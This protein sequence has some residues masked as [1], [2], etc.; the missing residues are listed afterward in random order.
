MRVVLA[1]GTLEPGRCGVGDFVAGLAREMGDGVRAWSPAEGPLRLAEDETLH[2]HMP[3]KGWPDEMAPIGLFLQAPR[4]RRLLTL[5][6]WRLS[7]PARKTQSMA[8][9]A[10]AGKLAFS[11]PA[12]ASAFPLGR[13]P[14]LPVGPALAGRVPGEGEPERRRLV[15]FGFLSKS[16]DDEALSRWFYAA[17]SRGWEE[18]VAFVG[19]P[20]HDDRV[21]TL[22][23]RHERLEFHE[24]LPGAEIAGHLRWGDAGILPFVDGTSPRRT[25]LLGLLATGIPVLSPPPYV[26]PFAAADFPPWE[27]ATG[28]RALEEAYPDWAA[29]HRTLGETAGWQAVAAAHREFHAA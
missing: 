8:L 21:A 23:A 4:S 2:L 5:H 14:V 15:F 18:G 16:K 26:E 29:R 17:K 9:A 12:Q 27:P 25:T 24:R 20:A 13:Q 28:L 22:R 3:S 7:H 1:V 6:E 19:N 11:D 10:L